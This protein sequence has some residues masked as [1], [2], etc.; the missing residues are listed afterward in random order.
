MGRKHLRSGV[1]LAALTLLAACG[2]GGGTISTPAPAP[3]PTLA[4]A[5]APSPTPT[6]APGTG[7]TPA[8]VPSQ[9]DTTEFRRSDGP[10]Q[11]NAATAWGAGWT[12]AGVTIATVDTGIDVD[13]P[14]FAG[15]IAAASRDMFDATSDRGLNASDD[16]GTNVAMVA[17]AA[18]NG[19]GILG[20][21]WGSTI[22]A[23]RSDTPNSCVADSGSTDPDD[24]CSFADD[25]IAGAIDYATAHG[26]KVIN[27]SL[28]GDAPAQDVTD[29]VAK[30][31]AAG[32]IIVV[33]AGNDS[34]VNPDA[35]GAGV[36]AAGG[37]AVIIVGS[38]DEKGVI[39]DFSD[40]AGNQPNHFLTARG[41]SVCCQYKDGQLYVDNDGFIYLLSGTSF[42]TPQVAGAAALLAQAFPNLTGKQ[43]ADILL[44]SA[45]DAGAAGTDAV[46]GRGILDIAKAFQPVGATS[47]AGSAAPLALADSGAVT[48]A[49]MGDATAR[50]SLQTVVLDEYSRAFGVDLGP[51]LRGAVVSQPLHGAVGAQER[52]LT[53]GNDKAAIAFTIDASGQRGEMPHT[54]LLRLSREDAVEAR[55]LAARVA[56]QLAPNA[57]MAFAFAESSDGLVAELQGQERPAFM[58]AGG[59]VGDVGLYRST[60]ASVALRRQL[61]PWGLTLSADG[62]KTWSAAYMHRAAQLRGQRDRNGVADFGLAL[63]RRFGNLRTSIALDWMREDATLL[64]A[65]FHDAFGLAGADTLFLD[66][67]AGWDIAPRWRLGAA[68]RNGWT[69]ARGGGLIAGGSRLTSRSWSFD[70]ARSGVFERNDSLAFRLSQPLRVESG[71]LNLS[72]PVDYSYATLSPTYG[73]RTLSLA[74]QGRELDAELAWTGRVFMGDAAASLFVRKDPGHYANLPLDEG[75]AFRWSTGF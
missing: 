52:H 24:D 30:A 48:S 29:A 41:E 37:G 10:L 11:H 65:E 26:A 18:R 39:S 35:F 22:L 67:E 61:G 28:G 71:G 14:E 53:A 8:P 4:P 36:D 44:R 73:I 27:L 38:V 40:R 33:A 74:P 64:G 56:L 17:A 6:P 31:A 25:T 62:G 12:G 45:F 69:F 2:G 13:S 43:I 47:L 20:I 66:A 16:H 15:R 23:L 46:Y 49:A 1:A 70:L 72:L 32:L 7:P 75:V 5:P 50:A 34:E 68:L 55:V 21:A 58:V 57:K 3:K 19:T 9:F 42:A 60:D 63:D 54:G 51:T 59:S